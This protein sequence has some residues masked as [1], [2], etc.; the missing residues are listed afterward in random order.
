MRVTSVR[1]NKDQANKPDSGDGTKLLAIV[2]IVL[3]GG[4]VISHIRV[5][6]SREGRRIVAMPSRMT[7]QGTYRDVAYPITDILRSEI[8]GAVLDEVGRA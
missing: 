2:S 5:I 7:S 3:D 1:V 4:M 6:E 8:H